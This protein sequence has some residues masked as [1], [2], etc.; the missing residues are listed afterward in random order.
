MQW[1]CLSANTK[2]KRIPPQ[3]PMSAILIYTYAKYTNPFHISIIPNPIY[4]ALYFS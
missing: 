3:N 4:K 2:L 1:T